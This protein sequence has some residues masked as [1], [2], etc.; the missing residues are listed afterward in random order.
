[1]TLEETGANTETD[2]QFIYSTYTEL[3]M[4]ITAVR[5]NVE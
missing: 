4:D 5:L 3:L 2:K 1:V